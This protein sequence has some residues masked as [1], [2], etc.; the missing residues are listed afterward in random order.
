ME[1]GRTR[2]RSTA[3]TEVPLPPERA[4]VVQLRPQTDPPG[5]LFV[6]RIEHIASGTVSR[7][8]SAA[9][10]TDFIARI[11]DPSSQSAQTR[12]PCGIPPQAQRREK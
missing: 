1:D 11:C 4:F 12:S 2:H 5:E 10:L 6:G 3:T 7:F 9:E 8:G